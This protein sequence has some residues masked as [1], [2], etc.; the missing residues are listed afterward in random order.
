MTRQKFESIVLYLTPE[1]VK[2]R[3]KNIHG[4]GD[5]KLAAEDILR[6]YEDL[7]QN[8]DKL[9]INDL[10]RLS[11]D[12][13]GFDAQQC[14]YERQKEYDEARQDVGEK[15]DRKRKQIE[16]TKARYIE[17]ITTEKTTW[18]KASPWA[19]RTLAFI[20]SYFSSKAAISAGKVA[21]EFED[22]PI[23]TAAATVGVLE[24]GIRRW[25]T[26]Q[27][28]KIENKYYKELEQLEKEFVEGSSNVR[29]WLSEEKRRIYIRSDEK[30]RKVYE[31]CYGIEAAIN[32]PK[33]TAVEFDEQALERH[34][35]ETE[36]LEKAIA[37]RTTPDLIADRAKRT[38]ME[39]EKLKK[40]GKR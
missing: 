14:R 33:Q 38:S 25:R 18:D 31:I 19:N 24:Y 28:R 17:D 15:R 2:V 27:K 8:V 10:Y 37:K 1:L 30:L 35:V 11:E 29:N 22:V 23:L 7:S 40:G 3:E 5:E 36:A 39:L 6:R 9:N 21:S 26:S 34:G 13:V 12:L 20:F 32:L 4:D 16:E